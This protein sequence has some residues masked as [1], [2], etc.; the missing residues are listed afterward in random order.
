MFKLPSLPLL[1]KLS[2]WPRTIRDLVAH[3]TLPERA[4]VSGRG[5]FVFRDRLSGTGRHARGPHLYDHGRNRRL[6]MWSGLFS[7]Y[8]DNALAGR[9]PYGW[10]FY[11][12]FASESVLCLSSV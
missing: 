9:L 11:A 4:G 8:T 10:L 2:S 12:G 1:V 5:D 3:Q 7:G 6:H